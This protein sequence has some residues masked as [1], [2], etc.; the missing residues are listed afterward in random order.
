MTVGRRLIPGFSGVAVGTLLVAALNGCTQGSDQQGAGA[1][2][3]LK[4]SGPYVCGLL[5]KGALAPLLGAKSVQISGEDR[6]DL[7]RGLTYCGFSVDSE[8]DSMVVVSRVETDG[9][10]RELFRQE[11]ARYSD[12]APLP[13]GLGR[14]R[15]RPAGGGFPRAYA[16]YALFRCHDE[17]RLIWFRLG[18]TI[19]SRDPIADGAA[20]MRMAQN[21]YAAVVECEIKPGTTSPSPADTNA[22]G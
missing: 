13:E 2:T 11:E 1:S 10:A 4:E 21:R 19:E 6:V 17:R 18:N 20:L 15:V 8:S 3:P 7:V 9:Q 22:S 16:V 14:G 5:P 12:A